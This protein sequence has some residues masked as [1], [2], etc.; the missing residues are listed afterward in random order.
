MDIGDKRLH[1]D[2][3]VNLTQPPLRCDGLGH[4]A[5]GILFCEQRLPLQVAFFNEI[6][7]DDAQPA[8]ACP[9]QCLCLDGA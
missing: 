4:D 9:A 5:S 7:I 2:L 3:L 1:S 6:P 8:H